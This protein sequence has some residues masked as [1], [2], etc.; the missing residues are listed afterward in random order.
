VLVLNLQRFTY[1]GGWFKSTTPVS[2]P[3][4]LDTLFPLVE[5]Q[6]EGPDAAYDLVGVVHHSGTM[7]FGHYTATVRAPDGRW[8]LSARSVG[9]FV[10]LRDVLAW[11]T[12]VAK[13]SNLTLATTTTIGSPS[14]NPT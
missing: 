9:D 7:Q 3:L 2:I 6:G 5:A 13:A 1:Q 10:R 14:N 12:A 11:S 8:L 4:A